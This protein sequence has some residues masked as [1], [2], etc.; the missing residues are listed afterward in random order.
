MKENAFQTVYHQMQHFVQQQ[1]DESFSARV[2]IVRRLHK[3]KR[4]F[5]WAH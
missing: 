2:K 5:S 3:H 1:P 4:I